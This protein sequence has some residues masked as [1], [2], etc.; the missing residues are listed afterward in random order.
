MKHSILFTALLAVFSSGIANA[1]EILLNRNPP[2]PP[3]PRILSCNQSVSFYILPVS[4][5]ID[6]TELTVY[7]DTSVGIATITV[8]DEWNNVIAMEE[9]DTDSGISLSIPSS[10]W[11][12]GTYTIF[13]SYENTNLNGN[14]LIE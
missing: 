13:I 5:T 1:T 9:L 3:V 14:F 12:A 8:Y 4:A 7:F 6:E 11:E 2:P 10:D